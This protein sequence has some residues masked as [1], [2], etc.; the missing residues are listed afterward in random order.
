MN[1]SEKFNNYYFSEIGSNLSNKITL[2]DE[3]A[4]S[5]YLSHRMSPSLFLDPTYEVKVMQQIYSLKNSNS[6]GTDNISTK[7]IVIAVDVLA[8]PL[9]YYLIISLTLVYL[10]IA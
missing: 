2:Q 5:N 3:N 9:K 1:I 6:C 8:T 10:Q 7:F 4:F